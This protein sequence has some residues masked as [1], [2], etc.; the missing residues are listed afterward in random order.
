[1]VRPPKSTALPA[2]LDVAFRSH[3]DPIRVLHVEDDAAFAELTATFL[4]R[5]RE[6]FDVVTELHERVRNQQLR[7]ELT[8]ERIGFAQQASIPQRAATWRWSFQRSSSSMSGTTTPSFCRYAVPHVATVVAPSR[9]VARAKGRSAL[10]LSTTTSTISSKVVAKT[11][12]L[13]AS[14]W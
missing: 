11:S 10:R 3:T 13:T 8:E 9:P 14:V 4:E 2:A 7:I 1:M 12:G 5:E 6:E